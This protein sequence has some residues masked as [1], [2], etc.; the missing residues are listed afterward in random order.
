MTHL[1]L[2]E[3]AYKEDAGHATKTLRHCWADSNRHSGLGKFQQIILKYFNTI[4]RIIQMGTALYTG[5]P[6]FLFGP[7]L[8]L[9]CG[10][11]S[12]YSG[13]DVSFENVKGS[14]RRGRY[15]NNQSN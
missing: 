9:T 12:L 3:Q 13:I 5:Q 7:S 10:I 14:I 11:A 8:R 6:S 15:R 1:A 4:H 2:Q